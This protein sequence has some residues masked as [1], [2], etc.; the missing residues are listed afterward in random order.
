MVSRIHQKL[1]TAGLII[2]IIALIA[3]LAG[4]A[5]AAAGLNSK[6]KKE[7][8]KIAKQFAGKPGAPG[9]P[10]A[11]GPAGPQGP[12]GKNGSSGT[13]GKNGTD[14]KSV[15][16]TE[17]PPGPGEECPE[18]GY[19]FEVEGSG[20]ENFVCNGASSTGP[21]RSGET[22][23]GSW[24]FSAAPGDTRPLASISYP[25]EWENPTGELRWAIGSAVECPGT[26]SEPKAEPGFLC[27]YMKELVGT[28][29]AF[30]EFHGVGNEGRS[31][32]V[33]EFK[34]EATDASHGYGVWVLTAQ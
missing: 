20:N 33:M 18:G 27:V 31:G 17:L 21:L 22:I 6:Q 34:A 11:Q 16:S 30:P 14:G 12:A 7:V 5:F 24:S 13:D 9:Q 8:K 23:T 3:A 2:A 10:G 4:T 26:L 19:S 29:Q 1:G 15:V 28:S 32:A 25:R